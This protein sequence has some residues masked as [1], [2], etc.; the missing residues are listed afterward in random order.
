MFDNNLINENFFKVFKLKTNYLI[1]LKVL[2]NNFQELQRI[3]HPD[4]FIQNEEIHNQ[5]TMISSYINQGFSILK[6]PLKRAIY[7]LELNK[8]PYNIDEIANVS[9]EFIGMQMDLYES[10]EE[11]MLN[12]NL[13]KIKKIS[14]ENQEKIKAIIKHIEENF[15]HSN[16]QEV[17]KNIQ[18]LSFYE[19]ISFMIN[20]KLINIL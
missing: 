17:K 5:A 20:E 13:E 11:A 14:L 19:K 7:L 12:N 6:S 15:A 4:N 8:N 3:Y 16:Y 18:S 9:P 2:K 1:D 10:I